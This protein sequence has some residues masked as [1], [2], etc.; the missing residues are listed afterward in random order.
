MV[1]VQVGYVKERAIDKYKDKEINT[2]NN[3]YSSDLPSVLTDMGSDV[4][5]R[6]KNGKN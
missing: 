5:L 4:T 3:M 2:K 1:L 6:A